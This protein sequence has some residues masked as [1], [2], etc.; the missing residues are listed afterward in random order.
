M[1][2][3]QSYCS[4]NGDRHSIQEVEEKHNLKKNVFVLQKMGV[5][6]FLSKFVPLRKWIK[7]ILMKWYNREYN[8]TG[9]VQKRA[10]S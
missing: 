2:P 8:K 5:N 6:L 4:T 9:R 3:T 10:G 7:Y 1:E